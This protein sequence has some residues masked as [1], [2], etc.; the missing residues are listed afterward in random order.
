MADGLFGAGVAPSPAPERELSTRSKIA[1]SMQGT[2]N[3]L[4]A[5][6]TAWGFGGPSVTTVAPEISPGAINSA[7]NPF[8]AGIGRTGGAIADQSTPS[9]SSTIQTPGGVLSAGLPAGTGTALGVDT[10][11]QMAD[12]DRQRR[13]FIDPYL[14]KP[15][16]APEMAASRFGYLDQ[17]AMKGAGQTPFQASNPVFRG[18]D[19]AGRPTL[20]NQAPGGTAPN[21]T[22]YDQNR[23]AVSGLA[24][25]GREAVRQAQVIEQMKS[26]V[27][28]GLEPG[29]MIDPKD[30]SR[31]IPIPGSMAELK[32]KQAQQEM[33]AKE[34]EQADIQ[35]AHASRLERE[36]ETANTVLKNIDFVLGNT[37]AL[38]AGPGGKLLSV[39]WGSDAF[40][41]KSAVD[42]IKANI[43]FDRLQQMR[44]ESPTGGA[45]GQVA[46]RELD[47]LQATLGSLEQAQ[48]PARFKENLQAVKKHYD[49]FL[50][51]EAGI[52][53]DSVKKVGRFEVV[54]EK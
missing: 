27:L 32:Y 25:Q 43:G 17:L 8:M 54:E 11:R 38:T 51:A 3:N 4:R 16:M 15:G 44:K 39:A 28:K 49:R 29:T 34:Q 50:K 6:T 37:N 47:F 30:P 24:N 33:G 13:L 31:V 5:P 45:L 20:T 10:M 18:T 1:Q 12:E 14:P 41:V 46:V 2:F 48:S 53:P 7:L 23:A 35:A 21:S 42:T 26:G 9:M 19:A 36:R 22:A 52:N 40:D